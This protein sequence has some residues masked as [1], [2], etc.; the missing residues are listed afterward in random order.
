MRTYLTKL[1]LALSVVPV[2]AVGCDEGPAQIARAS[3]DVELTSAQREAVVEFDGS[4][5][6]ASTGDDIVARFGRDEPF[7][8]ESLRRANVGGFVEEEWRNGAWQPWVPGENET[9]LALGSNEV[10]YRW[11]V[12]LADGAES[13]TLRIEAWLTAKFVHA[14]LSPP[15]EDEVTVALD[16]ASVTYP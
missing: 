1:L 16:I 10:R 13:G 5:V 9:P 2:V 7:D 4:I 15:T 6:V 12:T 8:G 3:S 11:T 14:N